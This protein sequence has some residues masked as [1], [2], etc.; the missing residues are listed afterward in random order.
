MPPA[1]VRFRTTKAGNM[2]R[3]STNERNG[4][5]YRRGDTLWNFRV[6]CYPSEFRA[7]EFLEQ[8]RRAEHRTSLV[9]AGRCNKSVTHQYIYRFI[10]TRIL[11]LVKIWLKNAK[12]RK[13]WKT[14]KRRGKNEISPDKAILSMKKNF[15]FHQRG[16]RKSRSDFQQ[17]SWKKKK[18]ISKQ[19]MK[20]CLRARA[21]G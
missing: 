7:L 10:H 19:E 13:K 14:P 15:N 16:T 2:K 5:P 9:F 12:H 6:W 3:F 18:K 11:K 21:T 8:Q 17:M 20:W 1:N 4:S